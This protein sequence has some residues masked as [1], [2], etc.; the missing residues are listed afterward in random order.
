MT[1]QEVIDLMKSSKSE[2]EWNKNCD[3]VK[4]KCGGY[5]SFWY[6]KIVISGLASQTAATWGGNAEIH[7][8][9]A[10]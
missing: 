2:T 6:T 3:T 7:V 4:A 10:K 9:T 8:T 1:E 5:P